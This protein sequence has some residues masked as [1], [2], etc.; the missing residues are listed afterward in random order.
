[1]PPMTYRVAYIRGGVED[2][3]GPEMADAAMAVFPV[4]LSAAAGPTIEFVE[5]EAGAH[6][7]RKHGTPVPAESMDII[8]TL[9]VVFKAPTASIAGSRS[10]SSLIRRELQ[11]F[12]NVN[13]LRSYHGIDNPLGADID[14][15]VV[16]ENNEGLFAGLNVQPSSGT[17]IDLRV[18]TADAVRRL[19]RVAFDLARRRNSTK[20]TALAFSVAVH[21]DRLFSSVCEE[22]AASFPELELTVQK[23]D[24]FAGSFVSDPA[25]YDVVIAPNEWGS[26][27]TDLVAAA[28]GSVGLAARSNLGER[29]GCFEPIHGTAPG[30]AGRGTV[31][32]IS[33]I[34][35]GKLL[36]DWLGEHHADDS[37]IRAAKCLQ[38]AVTTVLARGDTL[39]R[40]LGG[41]ATTAELVRAVNNEIVAICGSW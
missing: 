9:G 21:G 28:C 20:V 4:L 19:A 32:P 27:V 6:C 18:I 3:S 36:L 39:T 12:A 13:E 7:T 16:R 40:D 33:Q 2:H 25:Q 30:K 1:M 29:T 37:S 22:E 17:S 15:L 24:S 34:L 23:V 14:V 11:A 5:V 38:G 10:A 8:R 41:N 35:A 31:N 26:I